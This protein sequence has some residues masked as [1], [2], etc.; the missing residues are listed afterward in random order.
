MRHAHAHGT[1]ATWH[2][3]DGEDHRLSI[4]AKNCWHLRDFLSTLQE[5]TPNSPEQMSHDTW[6]WALSNPPPDVL[7]QHVVALEALCKEDGYMRVERV[8]LETV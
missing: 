2:C 3:G 8:P 4:S 7:G 1:T 6:C 5:D